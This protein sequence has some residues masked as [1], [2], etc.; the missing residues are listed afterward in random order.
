MSSYYYKP[1]KSPQEKIE[2]DIDLRDRIELIQLEFPGYGYRR[3]REHFLREGLHVN[4]KKLRRIMREY[5]LYSVLAK[6]WVPSI[7]NKGHLDR[8]YP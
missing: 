6:E 2:K 8:N 1:E 5:S 4:A 7:I 3:I